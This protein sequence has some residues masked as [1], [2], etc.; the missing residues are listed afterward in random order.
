M[1]VCYVHRKV[2]VYIVSA[3]LLDASARSECELTQSMLRA[4]DQI[5]RPAEVAIRRG[6]GEDSTN[7]CMGLRKCV[8]GIVS[9]RAGRRWRKFGRWCLAGFMHDTLHACMAEVENEERV[10]SD[11]LFSFSLATMLHFDVVSNTTLHRQCDE[12]LRLLQSKSK[13]NSWQWC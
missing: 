12:R 7:P 5:A 8:W 10:R 13:S 4:L 6:S 11:Q 1:S 9:C 3:S 2:A